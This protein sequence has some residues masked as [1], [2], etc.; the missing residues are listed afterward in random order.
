[1]LL[2]FVTADVL[3]WLPNVKLGILQAKPW[4]IEDIYCTKAVLKSIVFV[5]LP[6]LI[7]VIAVVPQ[8]LNIF[9]IL[10]T[11]LVLNLA[12]KFKLVIAVFPVF[13]NIP[14]IVVTLLVSNLSPKFKL[15]IA[16]YPQ[17]PNI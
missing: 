5:V 8:S 4:N 15:V 1:M 17:S 2:I 12:P 11:L 10:V 3:N 14:S 13:Q 6:I 9:D 16:V 7:V